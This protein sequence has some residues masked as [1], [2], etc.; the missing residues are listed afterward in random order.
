MG[1]TGAC[2]RQNKNI[3][4]KGRR[5][6]VKVKQISKLR[7]TWHMVNRGQ[8]YWNCT[9]RKIICTIVWQVRECDMSTI[10]K[11]TSVETIPVAGSRLSLEVQT[12]CNSWVNY[13]E[14]ASEIIREKCIMSRAWREIE[15]MGYYL[16]CA[17]YPR[18]GEIKVGGFSS[19]NASLRRWQGLVSCLWGISSSSIGWS[20]TWA[21]YAM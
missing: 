17:T 2:D 10:W 6:P 11:A 16:C 13:L 1:R 19:W 9:W 14:N 8:L 21:M 18:C 20:Y 12:V 7:H 15:N 4:I 3:K 5:E